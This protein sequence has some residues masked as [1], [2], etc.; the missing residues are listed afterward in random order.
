M[1]KL[2]VAALSAVV[3]AAGAVS[4]NTFDKYMRDAN[5]INVSLYGAVAFDQQNLRIIETLK[6]ATSN[7]TVNV[8]VMSPGG[9]V[10]VGNEIANAL[11]KTKAKVTYHVGSMAA[12]MAAML[13][14]HADNIDLSDRALIMYHEP[15]A[16]GASGERIN[17]SESDPV[18]G[19]V[20]QNARD[21]FK[22]CGFLTNS[23]I[24]SMKGTDHEVW[25]TGKEIKERI[26]AKRP[27]LVRQ[28]HKFC[29]YV[30]E[31]KERIWN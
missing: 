23:E 13:I 14:C 2:Q 11:E 22:K 30:S 1:S 28:Y 5:T 10:M 21:D 17:L 29:Q 8:W 9:D 7:M 19:R 6:N 26:E 25:L 12:S 16:T 20:L 15:Y 3:I 18:E 24:A 27:Y 4:Y 31:L